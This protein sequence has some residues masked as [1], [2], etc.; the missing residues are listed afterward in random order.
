[1]ECNAGLLTLLVP[2]GC[3]GRGMTSPAAALAHWCKAEAALEGFSRRHMPPN[4]APPDGDDLPRSASPFLCRVL[5]SQSACIRALRQEVVGRGQQAARRALSTAL[6]TQV[7]KPACLPL[8]G[9]GRRL[10]TNRTSSNSILT[11][12]TL[13]QPVS[14]QGHSGPD[15]APSARECALISRDLGRMGSACSELV[16]ALKIQLRTHPYGHEEVRGTF[17]TTR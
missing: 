7:R 16:K 6:L 4:A 1:M 15:T 17:P 5:C 2:A 14:G 13:N 9:R 8:K 10:V 11:L 12:L 3:T